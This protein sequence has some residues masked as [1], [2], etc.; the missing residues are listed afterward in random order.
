MDRMIKTL[1]TALLLVGVV[2]VQGSHAKMDRSVGPCYVASLKIADGAA[3]DWINDKVARG[4]QTIMHE[5]T[6]NSE[7]IIVIACE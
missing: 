4:F 3:D 6:G 1:G 2:F 5:S 7:T